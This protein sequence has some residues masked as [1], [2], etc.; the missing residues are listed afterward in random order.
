MRH[1]I[2]KPSLRYGQQGAVLAVSLVIL[3]LLSILGLA[4]M[5]SST[6][7]EKMAANALHHDIAFQVTETVSEN[8]ISNTQNMVNAFNS[9]SASTTVNFKHST[10]DMVDATTTVSYVKE[11]FA[12]GFSLSGSS[13][14]VSMYMFVANTVG[15]INQTNTS[16]RVIQGFYRKAPSQ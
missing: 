4:V 5:K 16:A 9:T 7:E 14:K 1:T 2:E 12:P 11:S 15:T 8:E 10:I 6:L 3:F 13:G